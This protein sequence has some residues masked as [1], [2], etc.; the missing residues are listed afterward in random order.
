MRR[1]SSYFEGFALDYPE[2]KFTEKIRYNITGTH[3]KKEHYL[4]IHD[5]E[6]NKLENY[7]NSYL[8]ALEFKKLAQKYHE[9][10]LL[11]NTTE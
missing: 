6:R 4:N 3:G 1:S 10:T 8:V 5:F 7:P 2:D 9:S 11:Q